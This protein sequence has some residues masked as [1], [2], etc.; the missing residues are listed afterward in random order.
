MAVTAYTERRLNAR[1][2]S[3]LQSCLK[4]ETAE[5]AAGKSGLPLNEVRRLYEQFTEPKGKQNDTK[6]T[7]RGA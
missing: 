1:I 4:G 2:N 5:Q 7:K 6:R 3:V